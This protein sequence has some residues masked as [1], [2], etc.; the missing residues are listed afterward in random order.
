MRFVLKGSY[1]NSDRRILN[2]DKIGVCF[3]YTEFN[4]VG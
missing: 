2:I 1:P 4:G 3:P